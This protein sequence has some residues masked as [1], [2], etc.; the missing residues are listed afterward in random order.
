[1]AIVMA[2]RNTFLL[3]NHHRI[4]EKKQVKTLKREKQGDYPLSHL[5]KIYSFQVSG[6]IILFSDMKGF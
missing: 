6:V 3:S 4:V 2:T 5:Y 1:M